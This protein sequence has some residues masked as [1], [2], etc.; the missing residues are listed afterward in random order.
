[1]LRMK[2]L[3]PNS[4]RSEACVRYSHGMTH[5]LLTGA[6]SAAIGAACSPLRLSSICLVA[7]SWTRNCAAC[8]SQPNARHR[9]LPVP[10]TQHSLKQMVGKLARGSQGGDRL[11]HELEPLVPGVILPRAG[12]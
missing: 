11:L 10:T 3:P 7:M 6:G 12:E 5:I 2:R 9:S 4:F 1:M 8:F